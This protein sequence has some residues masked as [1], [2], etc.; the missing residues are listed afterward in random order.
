MSLSVQNVTKF[1]A[2]Q[3][4]LDDVSFQVRSG[5][6]VALLGP[7]GAGKSTMMKIISCYLRPT[8]GKIV[9]CGF[10]TAIRPIDVKKCIGYLPENNPLYYDMYVKEYLLFAAGVFRLGKEGR[11]RVDE[12]IEMTAL[13]DEHKKTIGT[14]SRGYRQRVGLAQALIHNPEVLILDEPTSGLDPNQLAEVRT[15]IRDIGA[16]KTVILSTHIMQEVEAVCNRVIII[17]KGKIMA[18]AL[19]SELPLLSRSG[20]VLSVEFDQAV[21][22]E[23]V[24]KIKGVLDVLEESP[25]TFKI[26]TGS[27][28]DIRADVFRFANDN[29][30]MLLTLSSKQQS[31]EEVFREMTH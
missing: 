26:F 16:T 5:E 2:R 21:Q 9:V 28:T 30:L 10:D 7:N 27:N 22:A 1:Y 31:L 20:M 12:V 13:T 3:K 23:Q 6:V 18:N 15:L 29:G 19:T 4:A 8:S 24:R 25:Q 11:K 14:L 17:N